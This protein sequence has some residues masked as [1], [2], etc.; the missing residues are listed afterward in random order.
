V[1]TVSSMSDEPNIM[2]MLLATFRQS[3]KWRS[4]T[5]LLFNKD[6]TCK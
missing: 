6:L 2:Q 3:Q 4:S 5:N 1:E